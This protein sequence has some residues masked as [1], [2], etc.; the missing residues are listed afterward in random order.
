MLA[1]VKT[2]LINKQTVY[3]DIQKNFFKLTYKGV[4]HNW[5][6]EGKERVNI[7]GYEKY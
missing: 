6:S 1:P 5:M 2:H 7:H 3:M 4:N